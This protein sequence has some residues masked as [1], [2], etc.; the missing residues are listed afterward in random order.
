M[1]LR[2]ILV[3]SCLTA[4][5]ASAQIGQVEPAGSIQNSGSSLDLGGAPADGVPQHPMLGGT[6]LGKPVACIAADKIRKTEIVS[7]KIIMFQAGA[8][9][10]R[11]DLYQRCI[12]L[13]SDAALINAAPAGKLCAGNSFRFNTAADK[14]GGSCAYGRFTPYLPPTKAAGT[15]N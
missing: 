7:D 4:T 11:N 1:R 10:Y 6:V 13:K 8:Q 5:A 2:T 3:T 9:W 14:G 15:V 12:G